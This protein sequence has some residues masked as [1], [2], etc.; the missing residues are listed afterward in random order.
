LGIRAEID[1]KDRM[2]LD[3][4]LD[5]NTLQGAYYKVNGRIAL[6]P[7]NRRWELALYGR[8]LTDKAT[9]SFMLDAPLSAGIFAGWIE[10]PRV[11]GLQFRYSF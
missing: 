1:Y 4:D 3:Q 10:E 2:Y 11:I 8:N 5:P 6:S 7:L 9:Y